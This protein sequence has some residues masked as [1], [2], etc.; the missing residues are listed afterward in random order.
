MINELL[1]KVLQYTKQLES[2]K[3]M[4]LS[5]ADIEKSIDYREFGNKL[6]RANVREIM[7]IKYWQTTP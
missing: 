6:E 7:S 4:H 1:I 2:D 5:A 3:D